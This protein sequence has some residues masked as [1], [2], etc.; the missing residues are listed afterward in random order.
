MEKPASPKP[1]NVNEK[2]IKSLGQ[3]LKKV[4]EVIQKLETEKK[5]IEEEMAKPEI[6]SN[7]DKLNEVQKKFDSLHALLSQENVKWEKIVLEM[8]QLEAAG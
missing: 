8:D 3:E 6:Y 4:E 1:A 7:F 5:L 2:K